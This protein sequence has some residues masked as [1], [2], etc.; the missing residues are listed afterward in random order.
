MCVARACAQTGR[1]ARCDFFPLRVCLLATVKSTERSSEVGVV[2]PWA[3]GTRLEG[4][5]KVSGV[6]ERR[7]KMGKAS[8]KTKKYQRKVGW[9]YFRAYIAAYP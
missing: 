5:P 2:Q 7:G 9:D 3:K 8:K 6:G 4:G 1:E